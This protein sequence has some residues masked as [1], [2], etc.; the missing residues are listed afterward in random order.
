MREVRYLGLFFLLFSLACRDSMP[1]EIADVQKDIPGKIDFNF[2]IRPILSDRCYPCHGPDEQNRKGDL[3]LDLP[4]EAFKQLSSGGYAWVSGSLKKS[5][6]W[7]HIISED[8]ELMMPPPG[9]NL[10][11]SVA[12]KAMIAR[13]IK[14]GAGY[15]DHWAFIPPR[16]PVIPEDF[17]ADWEPL[18]PVD[19][20]IFQKLREKDLY[21]SPP[22]DRQ[23]LIRR[24]SFD[25]RGLPPSPEEIEAFVSDSSEASYEK[26]VDRFLASE[27]HAERMTMEWL[28]VARY[29][30]SHGM[31]ADGLRIM[32]PWRDWVV[33]AFKENLAYD[34]FITWQLAGD[35][36][37]EATQEQKL[38]TGF[39]RNQPLNSESGIVAEEF[40]LK[41][42]EDRTNTVAKAF[43]GLTMECA[44][45]HDHKFDPIS[46]KE[47]YQFSAFFNNV[48]ELGMIGN[49]L[50]F[51]PLL[52]LP[53]TFQEREMI[54]LKEAIKSLE[55]EQEKLVNTV[56]QEENEI[57][58]SVS[59][60][61]LLPSPFLYHA[62]DQVSTVKN[63]RGGEQHFIDGN[64]NGTVTGDYELTVGKKGNALRI[65][66][67]YDNIYFKNIRHFDQCDEFS[68]GIWANIEDTG[69][70][71]S[72][73]GNIGDKNNSWR[74]WLFFIDT[75]GRP[76]L[77]LVHS[78]SH[79]YL[80]V[81]A[82]EKVSTGTWTHLGFTYDGS[83]RAEGIQ[84]YINGKKS[85]QEVRF[86]HLYKD[87]LP[88]RYRNYD[89][90]PAK[91]VRM[92]VGSKYL[93]TETDDGVLKGKLDELNLFDR[94]LSPPEIKLLYGQNAEADDLTKDEI[95]THYLKHQHA[96]YIDNALRLQGLRKALLE[97]TRGVEEVMVMQEMEEPRKTFVL[98]RGQYDDLGEEVFAATPDA[99]MP[100]PEGFS[101]NRWGVARWLV[102]PD[103]PLTARVAV[104]RYWQMIFGRGLV[105]TPHDFGSQGDLPS[106]P[107]LLD[108]LAVDFQEH[109]WDL[110][111]L[112]KLMVM[113]ATYRQQSVL[114]DELKAKD[115]ENTFLARGPGYRLPI[116]MIRDNALAA[117]GLLQRKIGGSSVKPYQPEGLW[118]EK[119]EFSGFLITYEPDTGQDLYR[120]SMY[121]FIRRTSPPP[122]LTTF[123]ATGREF[124][125][126]KRDRTNTPTQAL[127]LMNDP[128]F[129]EAARK[130]AERVQKEG[131]EEPED[132]IRRGFL[133]ACGRTPDSVELNALLK[134]FHLFRKKYQE[135]V[136]AREAILDIGE[137]AVDPSL[138][139]IETAALTIVAN[140]MLN[141]DEA[142][143]KR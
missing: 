8:E 89:P 74:G 27:A 38:A 131:G 101:N 67:D 44:S 135:D 103:H 111:Y 48:H 51:G 140:T 3:R 9:S 90:D 57:L 72:I 137:S 52:M 79:N 10:Q 122:I 119:N 60:E 5:K 23:R 53:D 64:K 77:L 40:R 50:N 37:P 139:E 82:S 76:G 128:Q 15:K 108:W 143:M 24:L 22:A 104:N 1:G 68:A 130:L 141:F 17:P 59:Q 107:E 18:N 19:H 116:E 96:G 4:E 102:D 30:D 66:D 75:L 138:P 80:H 98:N 62:F 6:A 123:D 29:A 106:H 34:D 127:I 63:N 112:I 125:T 97:I 33:K 142:Y 25:L 42:T 136:L 47:Y 124:C 21:P 20:F 7:Q 113:S 95:L 11:L 134:Q 32:W 16:K 46:Q 35:L 78:L 55:E 73:I 45:C 58:S 88:V 69:H 26:L 61:I 83:A 109:N 87:I 126:V 84:L 28:D 129:L 54:R 115:P 110:R 117:S 121:T 132:Q 43:M 41:Y 56:V 14:D 49:D 85:A 118:K 70:F 36:L 133:L 120:R 94:E 12:E 13:W 2:H 114:T 93:F 92:G 99:I 91:P 86:D 81:V 105:N 71:Q 65:D 39:F 100:F 31:H